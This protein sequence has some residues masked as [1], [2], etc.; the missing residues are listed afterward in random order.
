MSEFVKLCLKFIAASAV[1]MLVYALLSHA[2]KP[3]ESP[4]INNDISNQI[5]VTSTEGDLAIKYPP[6]RDKN[7]D[8]HNRK[9]SIMMFHLIMKSL[10]KR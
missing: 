3:K 8:E 7:I 4:Y 10:R 1:A 6:K 2:T 9:T 5:R